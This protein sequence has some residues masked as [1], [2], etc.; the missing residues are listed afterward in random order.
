MASTE[1]GCT[2]PDSNIIRRNAKGPELNQVALTGNQVMPQCM[3]LESPTS[4]QLQ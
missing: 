2:Y 3:E 4:R 1:C